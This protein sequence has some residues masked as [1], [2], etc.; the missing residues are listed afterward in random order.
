MD[1]LP[2]F[3]NI[4]RRNRCKQMHGAGNDP[5]PTCLMIRTQTSAV[6]SVEI[7]VKQNVLA[8]VGIVVDPLSAIDWAPAVLA[9]EEN[10][11]QTPRNLLGHLIQVHLAPG[12]R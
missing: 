8:P 6:V 9:F 5:S 4:L 12:T 1:V 11:A 2:H 10:T 7:L 3:K